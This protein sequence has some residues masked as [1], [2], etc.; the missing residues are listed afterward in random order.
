MLQQGWTEAT[1]STSLGERSYNKDIPPRESRVNAETK[2]PCLQASGSESPSSSSTM[3][4]VDLEFI[5]QHCRSSE[6]LQMPPRQTPPPLLPPTASA[7]LANKKP[8]ENK[9]QLS[10][11]SPPSWPALPPHDLVWQP[12]NLPM[13]D[14]NYLL[15]FSKGIPWVHVHAMRPENEGFSSIWLAPDVS[16]HVVIYR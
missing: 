2:A 10:S 1:T 11:K 8:S 7:S 3:L 14:S 6:L 12:W 15:N 16:H 13:D 4:N 5:L 9:A